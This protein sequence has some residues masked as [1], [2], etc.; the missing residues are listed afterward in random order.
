MAWRRIYDI[1]QR[2]ECIDL[3]E[4]GSFENNPNNG[5]EPMSNFKQHGYLSNYHVGHLPQRF[6]PNPTVFI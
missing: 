2:D 6:R 3:G 5:L 4:R 1:T